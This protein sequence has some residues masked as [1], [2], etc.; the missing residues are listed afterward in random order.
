VRRQNNVSVN[1]VLPIFI[2]ISSF[3][4]IGT[5]GIISAL[6]FLSGFIFG[7]NKHAVILIILIGLSIVN[8]SKIIDLSYAVDKNLVSKFQYDRIAGGDVRYDVIDLYLSNMSFKEILLGKPFDDLFWYVRIGNKAIYSDNLHNS[9][10]LLHAKIGILTIPF[11]AI[12]FLTLLKLFKK[13]SL[14]LFLFLA[15]LARAFS[16]TVAFS[17]GYYDWSIFLIFIYAFDK[18]HLRKLVYDKYSKTKYSHIFSQDILIN[19]YAK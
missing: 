2:L 17:H 8:F 9:Y 11:F 4:S 14:I 3:I 6:I 19:E 1:L 12:I 13:D 10:L 18:N 16:D 15:V 5:G 7:K